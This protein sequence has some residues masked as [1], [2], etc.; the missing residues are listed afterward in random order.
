MATA[1]A[2]PPAT[3]GL[4]VYNGERYL[5]A[6][7]RALLHQ[8][9]GD[10]TLLVADNASTD[11]TVDIVRDAAA[12]DARV[13]LLPAETN[14]GVAW[15]WNRIVD[16]VESPYLR[17]V[18]YDDVFLPDNHRVCM[19]AMAEAGPEV[20]V[21]YPRTGIIDEHGDYVGPHDDGLHLVDERPSARYGRY[22]VNVR[23]VN[24]IFGVIRTDLVRRTRLMGA[25]FRADTVLLAELVLR[26]TFVELPD[27]LFHR[28]LHPEISTEKHTSHRAQAIHYDP[29]TG[30][31]S[32]Y[33]PHW[34]LG[35]EQL[36]AIARAPLSPTERIRCLRELRN[37]RYKR[38]V[39]REGRAVASELA[40]QLRERVTA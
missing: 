7:L 12:G 8:T 6:T 15:N 13:R 17:W 22:L 10:F 40:G 5:E 31:R 16:H 32:F 18:C 27:E 34:R 20:A 39:L 26:G 9:D 35:K 33:A 14:R 38:H 29:A 30:D 24:P 3:I 11:A 25:Y 37:W 23:Q 1:E 28:R 19:A 36:A 21:V 4:P 2:T